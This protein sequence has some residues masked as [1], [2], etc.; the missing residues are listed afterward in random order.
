MIP[1]FHQ[2]C[3]TFFFF[4]LR[5]RFWLWYW[6]CMLATWCWKQWKRSR[7]YWRREYN[8]NGNWRLLHEETIFYVPHQCLRRP[9][10]CKC[11]TL[12]HPKMRRR[13]WFWYEYCAG[14]VICCTCPQTYSNSPTYY[15]SIVDEDC[16]GGLICYSRPDGTG[17]VP[18]CTGPGEDDVSVIFA[19]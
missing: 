8:R 18:G 14:F 1:F 19:L 16:A 2:L 9:G 6:A 4:R 7:L 12:P 3:L 17:A 13:L 11:W 15:F 5:F 10:R